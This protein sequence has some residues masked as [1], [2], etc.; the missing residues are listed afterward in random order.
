MYQWTLFEFGYH[1]KD[2]NLKNFQIVRKI[3]NTEI[4]W[5]LGYMINQTNGLDAQFRPERLLSKSQFGGLL[6]LC[7]F[8]FIASIIAIFVLIKKLKRKDYSSTS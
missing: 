2:E 7:I 6:F 8:C 5:T 4:G 3:N 1:M